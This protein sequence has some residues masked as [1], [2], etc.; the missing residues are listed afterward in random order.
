MIDE[1]IDANTSPLSQTTLS[2]D[3]TAGIIAVLRKRFPEIEG[4][5]KD[6]I[7]YATQNRQNA[8]KN[9]AVEVEL[10]LVVGAQNSS[11]T[12]RLVEVVESSGT[13]AI[14]IQ[15]SSELEPAFLEGCSRIGIT[16][17]ARMSSC[18]GLDYVW[19]FRWSAL[20]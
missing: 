1:S 17:G 14:R 2:L 16:A 10:V 13:R 7:C 12:L 9:L 4:P 19:C 3:D 20:L 15:S 8:V 6:D 18:S 5:A 11:N